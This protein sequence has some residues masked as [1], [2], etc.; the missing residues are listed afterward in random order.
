MAHVLV[1][2]ANGFV[3]SHL[4]TQLL[5]RQHTV[6][7]VDWMVFGRHPL[8][9]HAD[10]P[11]FRQVRADVRSLKPDLMMG[12]DAVI[13][14]A[15]LANDESGDLNPELTSSINYRAR[16]RLG[17]LAKGLG[18]KR[19]VLGSSASVYG[20]APG[21]E[22]TETGSVEPK[23]AQAEYSKLAEDALLGLSDN[24]FAVTVFRGGNAYG[25]S[26]RMRF[27]LVLNALT[28][29]AFKSKKVAIAGAG[30]EQQPLIHV[31]DYSRAFVEAVEAPVETVRGQVFNLAAGNYS[32]RQIAEKIQNT[33]PLAIAVDFEPGRP[34]EADMRLN[35][36]KIAKLLAFKPEITPEQGIM[37]VFIAL[38]TLRTYPSFT[39]KT[40]EVYK[41]L[42]AEGR[43]TPTQFLENIPGKRRS[44]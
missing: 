31:R 23:T 37:E 35:T 26:R 40:A 12:V 36:Q 6:T 17:L 15:A 41:S 3:G 30:E 16:R 13:D 29:Q 38:T 18:V 32:V 4:V 25:L 27:D 34:A 22:A 33:L 1:T 24:E 21:R 44:G 39:T 19:Y 9:P 11:L 20:A 42:I 43:L 28:L 2:G 14:L 7:A 8:A 10:N 5:E